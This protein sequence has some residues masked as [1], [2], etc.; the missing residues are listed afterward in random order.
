MIGPPIRIQ[1]NHVWRH[2]TS[3]M[4]Y[5]IY[6]DPK[7]LAKS[8]IKNLIQLAAADEHIDHH[9]IIFVHSLCA[10]LGITESEFRGIIENPDRVRFVAPHQEELQSKQFFELLMLM[11][12]DGRAHIHEVNFCKQLALKMRIPSYKSDKMIAF[13]TEKLGEIIGYDDFLVASR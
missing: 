6:Q 11:N 8:H 5:N 10:K 7:D 9:E 4:N 13:I 12:I 3:Y 1:E 2:V